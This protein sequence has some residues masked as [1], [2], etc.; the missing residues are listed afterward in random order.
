MHI[1]SQIPVTTT[2]INAVL[3]LRNLYLN[4]R[5]NIWCFGVSWFF[6][7]YEIFYCLCI[8]DEFQRLKCFDVKH[9]KM[10]DD[11]SLKSF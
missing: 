5:S 9:K 6:G 3:K 2:K 4:V 11:I 7:V 1:Y 10:E 8:L